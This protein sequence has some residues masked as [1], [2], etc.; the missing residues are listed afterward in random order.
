MRLVLC[1]SLQ[2]Q[3]LQ[4]ISSCSSGKNDTINYDVNK[5][6][7]QYSLQ[8]NYRYALEEDMIRISLLSVGV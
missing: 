7:N 5:T 4:L 1:L 2:G 8:H 6:M 3:F